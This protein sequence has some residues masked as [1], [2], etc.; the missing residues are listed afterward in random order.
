MPRLEF[1][2]VHQEETVDRHAG[3]RLTI[4]TNMISSIGSSARCATKPCDCRCRLVPQ[5][6]SGRDGG[7]QA[8]SECGEFQR[9]HCCAQ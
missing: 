1:Q 2:I 8:G 9:N 4:L 6:W 3:Y 7:S 5:E